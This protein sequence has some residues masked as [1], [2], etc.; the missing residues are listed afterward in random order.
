MTKRKYSLNTDKDEKLKAERAIGFD[1]IT[2]WIE[3]GKVVAVVTHPNQE[4]YP[5]QKIY[6]IENEGYAYNVPFMKEGDTI[7]LKTV[8]PSRKA[9]KRFLLTKA[10]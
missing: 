9:T 3:T 7:I 2:E 1:K 5:G 6:V 8:F 4:K 10:K